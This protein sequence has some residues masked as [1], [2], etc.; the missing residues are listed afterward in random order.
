MQHVITMI[1]IGS[2][3]IELYLDGPHLAL[4]IIKKINNL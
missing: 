4:Y 1:L 3:C 2:E